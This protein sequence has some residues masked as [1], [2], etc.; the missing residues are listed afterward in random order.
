MRSNCL[1]KFALEQ[2]CGADQNVSSLKDTVET[3]RSEVVER[4]QIIQGN[5]VSESSEISNTHKD[6][7]LGVTDEKSMESCI[8][9]G[10]ISSTNSVASPLGVKLQSNRSLNNATED[11]PFVPPTTYPFPPPNCTSFLPRRTKTAE[12]LKYERAVES[13]LKQTSEGLKKGS[14]SSQKREYYDKSGKRIYHP[15]DPRYETSQMKKNDIKHG[16]KQIQNCTLKECEDKN[17]DLSKTFDPDLY[18]PRKY[19]EANSDAQEKLKNDNPTKIYSSTKEPK[20]NKEKDADY[21]RNILN[22]LGVLSDDMNL[23]E[24]TER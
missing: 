19:E 6:T 12:D 10:N 11:M 8:Q 24:L 5:E 17:K 9:N 3:V 16:S 7:T 23:D 20:V 1:N 21:K 4:A 14:N 22:D 2:M 18:S 15:D 13:F